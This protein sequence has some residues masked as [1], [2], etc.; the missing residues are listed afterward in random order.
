MSSRLT[1]PNVEH[2]RIRS[3]YDLV[4]IPGVQHDRDRVKPAA[5][6]EQH[7]LTIHHRQQRRGSDTTEPEYIASIADDGHQPV[8]PGITGNQ[9]AIRGD[10]V[11]Y[12]RHTRGT[13]R[14]VGDRQ[15]ALGIQ[16]SLQRY[17][18][19]PT[20]AGPK[21]IVVDNNL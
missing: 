4:E 15:R 17:G 2:S 19:L 14:G 20:Y 7:A 5:C 16:R 11:T 9:G 13:G 6:L 8:D 18:K 1:A 12:L 10:L 21:D 3:F